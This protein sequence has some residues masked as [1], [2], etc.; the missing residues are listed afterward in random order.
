M[1]DE[2]NELTTAQHLKTLTLLCVED[3]KTTQFLYQSICEDL[4]E[5]I[6][7]ADDGEDGY[8]KF[9]QNDVDVILS[10]YEMPK[11][12]GI[13]MISKIRENDKVIPIVFISAIESVDIFVDALE[14]NVNSFVKKPIQKQEFLKSLED[15]AKILIANDVIEKQKQEAIYRSYQEDLGFA[16][17][18]NIL[19]NDF[20][21]QMIDS[22]GTH[23]VDFLYQPLDVLSGDAYCARRIEQ[24]STFY[25]MVDGMGKGLSASLTAMIMTSFVNHV[26]DK[27][28]EVDSFDLSVLIHE[29]MEYIK[30]VLLE[31]EA[32]ALDYILIDDQEKM[33]YYAK[34]AMPVLLMENNNSEIVRL[35]SNNAPLSKWQDTFV[36]NSYDISHIKKFLIYS[37]G[38]VE[39]ETIFDNKPYNDFI[40]EDF[41]N[42]FTREDLK[43]S[44]FEK[45]TEQED[46]ITLIYIHDLHF[47]RVE[48]GRK[49]FDADMENIDLASEWY[50]NIWNQ[51]SSDAQM[52]Y[53]AGL[54]F[55][56]LYMNALEL[57][58]IHLQFQILSFHPLKL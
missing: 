23:L 35:K 31:E 19:R 14:L 46:D 30:P 52:V 24:G 47:D 15:T 11:L 37:D 48:L 4:V 16:K 36:M 2:I 44:F 1:Q 55:T 57:S 9:L 38:I 32:L 58:H 18:L 27:M 41:L 12:N 54:T 28:L 10:D 3:N 5:K 20:Y 6:I 42:S 17:E 50:E 21:Y 51:I 39:N 33:L 49:V 56:E 8:Q 29:T 26:I 34:F 45:I 13:E 53:K 40:E 25:L 22:T 7:F 43:K